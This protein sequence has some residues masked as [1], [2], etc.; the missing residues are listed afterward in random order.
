MKIIEKDIMSILEK[1]SK[2]QTNLV[3]VAA[4]Q[5]ITNK[6]LDAIMQYRERTAINESI[7]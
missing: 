2:I 7:R 5:E 6:I 4:R 1:F 3:S